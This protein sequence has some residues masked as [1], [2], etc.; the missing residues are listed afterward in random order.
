MSG[1]QLEE[2]IHLNMFFWKPTTI[3]RSLKVMIFSK[4]YTFVAATYSVLEP[5]RAKG[6]MDQF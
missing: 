2:D 5:L 1:F 4:I 6:G 3:I